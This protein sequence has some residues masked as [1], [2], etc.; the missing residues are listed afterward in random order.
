MN[1]A[2]QSNLL[3]TSPGETEREKI[4][5]IPVG[6]NTTV[7]KSDSKANNI[8]QAKTLLKNRVLPRGRSQSKSQHRRNIRGL[9]AHAAT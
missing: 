2:S 4:I 6:C 7:S 9:V 8:V 1:V 5:V 3:I